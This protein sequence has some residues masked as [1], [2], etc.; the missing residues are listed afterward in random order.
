M[1]RRV[2]LPRAVSVLRRSADDATDA[3]PPAPGG[4][5]MRSPIATSVAPTVVTAV[6]NGE[7]VM[8]Q[9]PVPTRSACAI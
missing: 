7:T 5:L 3:K 2:T 9:M 1:I 8:M 6:I 4:A